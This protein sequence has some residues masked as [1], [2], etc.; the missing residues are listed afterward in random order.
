MGR[1]VNVHQP[2]P[3]PPPEL[4]LLPPPLLRPP[5]LFEEGFDTP[6]AMPPTAADHAPLAPPPPNVPP[7]PVHDGGE[8]EPDGEV[9][10]GNVDARELERMLAGAID[11]NHLSIFGPRPNASRYGNHSSLSFGA[12]DLSSCSK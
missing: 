11:L 8:L 6:A 3:P 10:P 5:E 2:P 1:Y 7:P 4:R 12:D 9:P